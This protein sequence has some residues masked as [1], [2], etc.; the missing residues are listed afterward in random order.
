MLLALTVTM[1]WAELP[2][3]SDAEATKALASGKPTR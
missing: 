3:A 1:A 2:S